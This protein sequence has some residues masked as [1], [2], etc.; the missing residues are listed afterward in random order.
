MA[1][2]LGDIAPD[3]DAET[4]HGPIR[5]WEWKGEAWAVLFTHPRDF[6][7]VCT[8]ELGA[9]ARLSPEFRRRNVKVIGLSV[10]TVS[11][12]ERWEADIAATQRTRL[13]FPL[14]GDPQRR[15]ARLYDT[16]HPGAS[17]TSTVRAVFVIAPD[18]RIALTF[19]YP[20]STGRNF[21]ELL[22][23]IDALQLTERHAVATPADWRHGD[24]VIILA[25][26]SDDEARLRFPGGWRTERP[27]LRIVRQPDA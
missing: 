21:D 25:S 14:I 16:I 8:T 18:N 24:D 2:R 17:E 4:T 11:D 19:T 7:P 6:T 3:F 27:Y 26:L 15:V 22:R 23:V 9:V 12:H 1:L 5:F 10:D 13:D 20:A